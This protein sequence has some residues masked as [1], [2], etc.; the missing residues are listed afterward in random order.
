MA[1][2]LLITGGEK[3]VL[4]TPGTGKKGRSDDKEKVLQ[5]KKKLHHNT[6]N[7]GSSES[8]PLTR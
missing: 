3:T 2:E 4:G 8:S 6:S 7:R 1:K 5:G